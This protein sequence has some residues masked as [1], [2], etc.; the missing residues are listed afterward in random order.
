MGY[1][2]LLLGLGVLS[3][4]YFRGTAADYFVASRGI[5]S[6]LLL[7]SLF[8]TT[9]TAFAL[10]GSTGES[11]KAGIG[12]YGMMASSSGIIHSACFF[13][14]G[15]RLWSFG[16]RH[17]YITQIQF[18]RDRFES[19]KIGLVLFPIL[20]GLV[21]PYL[22]IGVMAAGTTI[23]KVTGGALPAS[24]FPAHGVGAAHVAAGAVPYWLGAAV[25]CI[26]VLTYV[27]FGGVRGTAWANAFQTIVFIVLG[28]VTF[29]VIAD[30]LGGARAATEAV[31][32]RNPDKLRRTVRPDDPL[33]RYHADQARYASARTKWQAAPE[34]ERGRPPRAPKKPHGITMLHFLSYLFIPLS[35]GMF[36]HLFQHWLTAKSARSFR[37]AIIAHPALI[38]LVWVPCILI[39]VWATSAVIDGK[40]V[41]PPG[42]SNPNAVLAVLVG[43]LAGPVLGGF[44]TAGILAAI[45]SSLDSQFLC[46]GSIFTNDIVGHYLRRDRLSDRQKVMIGR[47]FVVFIVIVTYLLALLRPGAVFT[48]GIWCFSGFAS[49]FPLVLAAVYWK[50]VTKAGAYASVL[51]TA[52]VWIWLFA[53]AGYGANREFLFLGMMP[54]ATIIAASTAAL[55]LV[56]LVTKAPSAA[57]LEK[58]FGK[59]RHAA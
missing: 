54:V 48:L 24:M 11:F 9:M 4:R 42:F 15:I 23:E 18:F 3:N 1:L 17:G 58:F 45:M 13:L 10:V 14:V 44:L 35:V 29:F 47:A 56:S 20:V 22:L 31:A 30:K 19:D 2:A 21:I 32:E 8:G 51:T 59:P 36:P 6:F 49:L 37:L 50:R 38:M 53:K 57:T 7:M 34:A 25:I 33:T 12:V 55:V 41:I 40:P 46:I 26:I 28:C 5:G 27:F 16:K 52:A 43:K 39:G